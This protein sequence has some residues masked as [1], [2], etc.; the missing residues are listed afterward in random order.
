MALLALAA[1]GGN[2]SAQT[3]TLLSLKTNTPK[4]S[5]DPALLNETV[6][7]ALC[8]RVEDPPAN[9]SYSCPLQ[10]PSW[11]WVLEGVSQN[12]APPQAPCDVAL[13]SANSSMASLN[14][15]FGGA[16][17]WTVTCSVSVQY[18]DSPCNDKWFGS[19]TVT[20]SVN[21]VDVEL[22]P[23]PVILPVG[24]MT[25]VTVTTTPSGYASS[26][27]V[28]SGDSSIASV[29]GSSPTYT[30]TGLQAGSTNL[31]CYCWGRQIPVNCPVYVFTANLQ[32][33]G[34]AAG[35]KL[36]PGG[37]VPLNANN[38]NGSKVTN[39]VPAVRDMDTSPIPKEK[40]LVPITLSFNG[41]L[42]PNWPVTYTLT[43]VQNGHAAVHFWNTMTK[44]NQDMMP[45]S[46]TY[47]V[48]LFPT[49]YVEGVAEGYALREIVLT[50]T[51]TPMGAIGSSTDVV[52]M[53]VTPVLQTLTVNVTKGAYPDLS[54]EGLNFWRLD[55]DKGLPAGK[56]A[57]T[58]STSA[59]MK[60]CA[61][62]LLTIQNVTIENVL[63]GGGGADLGGGIRKSWGFTNPETGKMWAGKTLVDCLKDKDV[64]Y[65]ITERHTS[66]TKNNVMT[67]T[68]QDGPKLTVMR[69]S[70]T[71]PI[72]I[73][74]TKGK[75]TEI[76]VKYSFA[77][78]A[79][80]VFPDNTFCPLGNTSWGVRFKGTITFDNP[81]KLPMEQSYSFKPS[82]ENRD[83]PSS[84][85]KRSTALPTTLGLP[86]ANQSKS[87]WW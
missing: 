41:S 86:I 65:N 39:G 67:V 25:S 12:G 4:F 19:A 1:C 17:L 83:I 22:S 42:P 5:P 68:D 47:P 49:L 59:L 8:A 30:V 50:L 21:V 75:K 77:D 27:S 34:L 64:P 78:T 61:G 35:D 11:Q 37:F 16:G 6:E 3:L 66:K 23:N 54:H 55:S 56:W 70:L 43:V 62:K 81:S 60:G 57:F 85:F 44:Q 36:N 58:I 80:W 40:D 73:M 63:K 69:D 38:D 13:N 72:D 74:P 33:N 46:S 20:V 71:L 48:G 14:G 82:S 31:L 29:S 9:S 52:N 32:M 15:S 18:T 45:Y 24:G 84:G 2:N 87:K 26:V 28:Y 10:G 76:D 51:V 7:A 53:T 79:V